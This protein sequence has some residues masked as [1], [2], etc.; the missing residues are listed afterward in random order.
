MTLPRDLG[1]PHAPELPRDFGE[2]AGRGA[3]P[4]LEMPKELGT[5]RQ[6]PALPRI[7][8]APREENA[9]IRSLPSERNESP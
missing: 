7:F 8:E 1:A 6:T 3:P 2:P 4:E 5:P 9:P